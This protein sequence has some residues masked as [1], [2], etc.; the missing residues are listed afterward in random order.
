MSVSAYKVLCLCSPT[1]AIKEA[2][3]PR[4]Y[5][6]SLLVFSLVLSP[7]STVLFD[8]RC[9]SCCCSLLQSIC[10]FGDVAHCVG[11]FA[12]VFMSLQSMSKCCCCC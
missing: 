5:I 8:V 6:V 2:A 9:L 4:D 7:S 12:L 11:L 1:L 3:L 10:V